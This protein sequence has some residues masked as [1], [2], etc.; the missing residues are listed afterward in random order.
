MKFFKK[1]GAAVFLTVMIVIIS[2]LLSFNIRFGNKCKDIIYGFYDGVYY[3]GEVQESTASHLKKIL[4]AA[5][6]ISAI[7]ASYDIDVTHLDY[8]IDDLNLG[9]RYSSDQISY[10][11]YCYS[12]LMRE[13]KDMQNRLND[14]ELGAENKDALVEYKSIIDNEAKSLETTGYNES[15]REF[16]REYA[17][18][19]VTFLADFANVRLPEYFM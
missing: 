16:N 10:L 1:K 2:T 5:E 13:T 15:V 14:K 19:P 3:N 12:E 4:S 17:R 7:A 8:A 18:F 9:F 11:Y 6:G